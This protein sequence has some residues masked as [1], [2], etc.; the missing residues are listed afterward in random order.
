MLSQIEDSLIQRLRGSLPADISAAAL[1][2]AV[3]ELVRPADGGQ[4][5]VYYAGLTGRPNPDSSGRV[6]MRLQLWQAMVRH[7]HRRAGGGLYAL[8][9][10]VRMLFCGWRPAG[11][12]GHMHLLEQSAPE[13]LDGT[14]AAFM[15]FAAPV[16][17]LPVPD[18]DAAVRLVRATW[19]NQPH[20]HGSV[21]EKS[22]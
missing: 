6:E 10:S 1:P 16:P 7:R 5:Y 20:N 17:N 9:D 12:A 3:G 8:L 14:W 19:E 2:D 13:L 11:A 15:T 21:V 18:P 4:V 22:S